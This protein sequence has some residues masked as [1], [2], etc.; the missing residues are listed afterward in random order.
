MSEPQATF[1]ASMLPIAT[2]R[3]THRLRIQNKGL[4]FHILSIRGL[5]GL[6]GRTARVEILAAANMQ[7]MTES[8]VVLVFRRKWKVVDTC[9]LSL[10]WDGSLPSPSY[11]A[12]F[13]LDA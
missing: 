10:F 7:S 11:S 12:S 4:W 1:A 9:G 8:V 6:R 3:S 2:T 5:L 13:H